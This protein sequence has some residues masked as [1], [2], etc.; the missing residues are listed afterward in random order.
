M[1]SVGAYEVLYELRS[2][3]MGSVL[4]GRRRGPGGFEKLVAIKTIRSELAAAQQV[5][6]M[7]LDEAAILARLAH[8]AVA[9]VHD[10]GEE[11]D[12][13]YLVM[14]YVAGVS[15][16][17]VI[18]L[19][20]P[21][22]VTARLLAEACRGLHAAH[23]ARDL[24]GTLLGVVHR[25]IS[26]DNILLAFDGRVKVIDFGIALIKGRHA[27]VTE[28]GM[29]KGKPPYMS[30]EQLKNEP[31]DR[32][33]DVFALGAVLWE[34]LVGEPLF[35]GDSLYAIARA[36]EHQAIPAPS[37]RAP[38]VP[39]AF[40]AIALG[41]LCRDRER[42]TPTAAL[43]AEQ[44][45]AAA[46]ASP[47]E[48]LEAWSHRTLAPQREVHR[49]WLAQ[50]LGGGAARAPMGRATG[51]VTAMAMLP[52]PLQGGAAPVE[53]RTN[54]PTEAGA[55]PV[56]EP[57][58]PFTGID[59]AASTILQ[60]LPVPRRGRP[61]AAIAVLA[62]AALLLPVGLWLAVRPGATEPTA[63][64]AAWV[65]IA[66][67]PDAAPLLPPDAALAA[68][69]PTAD[70]AAADAAPVR[71][72]ARV[73]D[74]RRGDRRHLPR[75]VDAGPRGVDAA[76]VSATAPG[77]L[78]VIAEP[79]AYVA[80]DGLS[81]GSTPILGHSLAAGPHTVTLTDPVSGQVR[82]RRQI[83]VPSGGTVRIE[84]P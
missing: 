4:L 38:G 64:D 75:A 47:G 19:R 33:S 49:R 29:L 79:Y 53:V 81:L 18:E 60:E 71:A 48:S 76:R 32:R 51:A 72:D 58:S 37:A 23:E 68:D 34:V 22:N 45:D 15:L 66:E 25:D 57:A 82:L 35:Q 24:G 12:N 63:A 46:A 17:Q 21:P 11:A 1:R 54:A 2:G 73:R 31:I 9:T 59:P 8:R 52:G 74:S 83:E 78:R 10:F 80:V 36:V 27:P 65:A 6:A 16:H 40:D 67:V 28:L 20:P 70:A 61:R 13:L 44:L 7:F 43:L 41:A 62:A 50:V 55:G 30:P 69:A 3:G 42:R 39:P 84:V 5:R 26:P 56:G 77:R 14:E